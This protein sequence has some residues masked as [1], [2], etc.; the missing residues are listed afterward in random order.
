MWRL[1]DNLYFHTASKPL[2]VNIGYP[3]G[4][5][6]FEEWRKLGFDAHSVVADPLFV[7]PA[8]DNYT[9]RPESPAFKLG[10]KPIDVSQVG[11]RLE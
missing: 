11:P 8:Q 3:K 4:K 6:S 5:V 7:D 10:F 2:A 1:D 9:L